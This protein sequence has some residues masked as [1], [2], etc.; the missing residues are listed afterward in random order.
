MRTL[1]QAGVLSIPVYGK[2]AQMWHQNGDLSKSFA[3]PWE[4]INAFTWE[5][6]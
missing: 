2:L 3:F 5:Q 1:A 6:V 4:A